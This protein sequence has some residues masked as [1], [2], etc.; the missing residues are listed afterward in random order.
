[1]KNFLDLTELPRLKRWLASE[2][3]SVW[4]FLAVQ[5]GAE[6]AIAFSALYWPE[7]VEIEGCVLLREHY[8]PANFQEWLEKL[9]GDKSKVERVINHVHLWDLFKL[10][11]ENIPEKAIEDLARVLSL[12]WKCALR[13]QFAGLDFDMRLVLDESEYGP[14]I[15]FSTLR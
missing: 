1:L 11:E 5:G 8:D 3:G 9:E 15:F 4:D 12:C 6:L 2:E 7:F 14:T 10:D 13:E